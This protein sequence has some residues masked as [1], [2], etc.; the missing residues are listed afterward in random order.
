MANKIVRE[1]IHAK[2]I[3]I[4]I[5][6]KDFENEYISLTDIAKYRNDNDPRFVIQNWMRNRNTVEFLAVWEELHNPDFNRVQF[7]AVRSEAGLNRFV[8]TPTKW[9]EQ[10]N[11]IGI[12][13]KAGRYGGG[14]Y[15]HSD[16]AMAF[17]TW[18]SP[19]FQ[20]YIMKDYR[21]LKQD[22]NSRF[23]LDWNLNRALSKVNYRIHTD[24][25][26]ENLIP[27]E[28]TPE[29]IAYTYASEA[30]LLNVAL[31]GQT[32]KQWKNNNPS[33]NG[34]VR[35]DANL[36]QLLVLANMESYNATKRDTGLSKNGDTYPYTSAYISDGESYPINQSDSETEKTVDAMDDV[37]A[38][39]EI[40]KENI[41]YD[42]H[43]K[44][45]EWQDKALYDELFEVIC[46]VVC[47]KH[48]TVRIAGEDYPYELVKSKFLKLNSSH[49]NYVI[50]CMKNTTT[51][52][53][54]IK[55]YMVTTLYN[56][57]S[58]INHY[59]QQEVQHDMYGG[60]WH[61]KGIV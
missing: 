51:K 42:H 6:T 49:L 53:T 1:I 2:G 34:N 16:I 47:V 61:E 19:E 40:I 33:K 38:Y 37:N 14:T 45:G 20:L 46:E 54:N 4:G 60:G 36:N 23:S 8:M 56:A 17:A 24:E 13:S 18:I 30:D 28:L 7:E 10:T 26:K 21:R 3:D 27:P 44:Y 29:Q 25:V 11:A 55:A 5:Y 12:V 22:E 43:M 39:I 15:A 50:G 57:P 58:T 59:Y 48:K 52:I 41:E 9:I 35:D 31:F 32:A